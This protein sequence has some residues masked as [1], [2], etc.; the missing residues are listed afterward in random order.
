MHRQQE[1]FGNNTTKDT[2]TPIDDYLEAVYIAAELYE[3]YESDVVKLLNPSSK[4]RKTYRTE[5]GHLKRESTL[6]CNGCKHNHAFLQFIEV[7]Y[8]NEQYVSGFTVYQMDG[9]RAKINTDVHKI[10]RAFSFNWAVRRLIGNLILAEEQAVQIVQSLE[11]KHCTKIFTLNFDLP[12]LGELK[13]IA[14]RPKIRMPMEICTP[15]IGLALGM[16]HIDKTAQQ[17][18]FGKGDMRVYL[19]LIGRKSELEFPYQDGT[20][21]IAFESEDN[22]YYEP[23]ATRYRVVLSNKVECI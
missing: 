4:A 21:N 15:S 6:I 23:Y 2:T 17:L 22:T 18:P 1:G 8:E 19:D 16:V 13:T 20:A 7:L 9:D 14:A 3:F 12:I 5:I 11:E 10:S